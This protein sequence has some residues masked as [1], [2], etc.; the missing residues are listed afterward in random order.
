MKRTERPLLSIQLP[1]WRHRTMSPIQ[2]EQF[3]AWMISD[4]QR[5]LLGQPALGEG[6]ELSTTDCPIVDI[7]YAWVEVGGSL[8]WCRCEVHLCP[9]GQ[10]YEECEPVEP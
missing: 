3:V 5:I 2:T 4:L 1:N 10:T 9:N 6:A 7:R 8:Q